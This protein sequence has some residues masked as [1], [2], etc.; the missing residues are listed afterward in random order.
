MLCG[1]DMAMDGKDV[2]STMEKHK[3]KGTR[4]SMSWLKKKEKAE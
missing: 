3:H 1:N 4:R 2:S